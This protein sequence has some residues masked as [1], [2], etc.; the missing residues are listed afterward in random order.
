MNETATVTTMP[1]EEKVTW[2]IYQRLNYVREQVEYIKKNA[3]VSGAGSYK[4][5]RHDD[6]TARVREHLVTAG[7]ICIQSLRNHKMVDTGTTTKNGI[8]ISRLEA[9]YDITFINMD[10]PAETVS[11]IVAAHALDSGDKAPGKAMSYAK[12]YAYLK[13]F[14]LETGEEDEEVV[15]QR[16]NNKAEQEREAL[17]RERLNIAIGEHMDSIQAIKSA[18]KDAEMIIGEKGNVEGFNHPELLSPGAEA[19]R[20]LG[21]DA[22]RDLWVAPSK[23]GPFTTDE[24][25]AMHTTSFREA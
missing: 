19:W 17:K 2:N 8:P 13:T 11:Q 16:A 7:V 5:V 14:D 3:S 12:K 23:G 21:P 18:I 6:V 25:K 24:R 9:E 22:Q 15:E 10:A 4:A 1:K 20:E